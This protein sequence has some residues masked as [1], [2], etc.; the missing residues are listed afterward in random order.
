[1][2]REFGRPKINVC[3]WSLVACLSLS[4]SCGG[5][6]LE[7]ADWTIPMPEGMRVIEHAAVPIEERSE[8]IELIEDLVPGWRARSR[9]ST[10]TGRG[11]PSASRTT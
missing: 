3:R 1:M 11:Q 5:S 2:M 8:K 10:D 6:G 7:F 4:V 9:H